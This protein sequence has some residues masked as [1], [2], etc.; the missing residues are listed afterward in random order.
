MCRVRPSR[1]TVGS[2]QRL[3]SLEQAP[4]PTSGP[5]FSSVARVAVSSA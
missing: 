2:D 4:I 3:T 1:A 5:I